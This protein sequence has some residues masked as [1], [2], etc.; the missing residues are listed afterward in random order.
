MQQL[1]LFMAAILENF[2]YRQL[3]SVWRLMG[4]VRWVVR[5]RGRSR[6]GRIRRHAT[7]QHEGDLQPQ[8]ASA[9]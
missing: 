6:W 1:R 7:W 4:M 8:E 2:G 5:L 3:N 9:G